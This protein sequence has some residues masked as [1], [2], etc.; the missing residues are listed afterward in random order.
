MFAKQQDFYAGLL[1]IAVGTVTLI[2]SQDYNMGTAQ[3]MGPG[4]FPTLL[5]AGLGLV[6][7]ATCVRGLLGGGDR[8]EFN[9][10]RPLLSVLAGVAVFGLLL[11][12]AGLALATVALVL[13]ARLGGEVFKVREI[14][15][16]SVALALFG[17]S[18]FVWGLGLPINVW[19][20]FS[21]WPN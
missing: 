15:V 11:E 9:T 3:R 20:T 17:T 5:S 4:Y 19:P 10:L 16:L 21:V 12:R 14:A 8:V 7:I 2:V 13:L 6:G 18:I 1:F